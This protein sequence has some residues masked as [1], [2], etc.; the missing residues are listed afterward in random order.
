VK[1][2]FILLVVVVGAWFGGRWAIE[3]FGGANSADEARRR[4]EVV[5]NGLRG[6][7]EQAAISMWDRGK[8]NMSNE[9]VAAAVDP[10]ANWRQ[11]K[12]LSAT[13][14]SATIDEVN[15]SGAR[16]IVKVTIDGRRFAIAVPP[17]ARMSWAD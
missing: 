9:E 7:D 14:G 6:Q 15:A 16:P 8:L 12:D 4:V 10:F 1:K 3:K 5:L 17:G 13:V 11:E 2:L